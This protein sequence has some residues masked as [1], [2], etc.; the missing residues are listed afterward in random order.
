[1]NY[2]TKVGFSVRR[3]WSKTW[4]EMLFGKCCGGGM[5]NVRPA[6]GYE[7]MM[8]QYQNSLKYLKVNKLNAVLLHEPT[9]E[10]LNVDEA[11]FMNEV[12]RDANIWFGWINKLLVLLT[13]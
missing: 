1:M 9:V 5:E 7:D 12:K 3:L 4:L 13:C 2:N 11:K 8:L 10:T 6:F